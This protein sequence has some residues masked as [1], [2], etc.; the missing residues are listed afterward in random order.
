VIA[1]QVKPEKVNIRQTDKFKNKG[2]IHQRN[3]LERLKQIEVN[4]AKMPKLIEDIRRASRDRA[5]A[6][7][8]EPDVWQ[9]SLRPKKKKETVIKEKQPSVRRPGQHKGGHRV[10]Y[11]KK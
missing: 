10:F 1:S 4:L 3:Q 8:P 5:I 11:K 2:H 6:R 7:E 9:M